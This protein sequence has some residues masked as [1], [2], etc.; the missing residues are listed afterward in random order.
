MEYL[1]NSAEMKQYDKNTIEQLKVPSLVLMERAALATADMIC[2]TYGTDTRILILAGSGNNGGDG[3]AVARILKERGIHAE[4]LLCGNPEHMTPETHQQTAIAENYQI[5]IHNHITHLDYDLYVDAILG[6]GLNKP[7][8][9]ETFELISHINSLSAPVISVDI[10]SGIDAS[11]GKVLGI[12]VKADQTVTY[13]FRKLG[14]VLYPGAA[15]AGTVHCVEMGITPYSF[16]GQPPAFYAYD[17]QDLKLPERNPAGNKGTFGKLFLIAGS[18]MMY[19]ACLFAALSAYRV[20]TGMVKILTHSDNIPIL[21]KKLPE[22]LLVSYDEHTTDESLETLV[23]EGLSWC[24]VSAVGPG[25]GCDLLSQKIL[26]IV[27]QCNDKP[28]VCDADALN[29]IAADHALLSTLSLHQRQTFYDIVFTP[30]LAEFAR[31]CHASLPEV[32]KDWMQKA[33]SFVATYDVTLACKDARSIVMKHD[34]A[35]YLNLT[36]NDGMATAGSGDVLTGIISG[37][38]AQGMSGYHAACMGEYLHGFAGDIAKKNTNAYYIMAQDIISSL[39]FIRKE[40]VEH[41]AL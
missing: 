4:I 2:S 33:F 17:F 25:I 23:K 14:L 18:K 24:T 9:G 6:I 27:F 16:L 30:H 35:A 37:L 26:A 36:G 28:I 7:I 22:A 34:Q 11:T 10:P 19:G 1:V 12:A 32:K 41:E 40:G 3:V 13:G 20:G 15:Y 8:E 5:P 29:L 21:K 31:L 39:Q 38:M